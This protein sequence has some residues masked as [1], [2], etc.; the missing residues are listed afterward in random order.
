VTGR[1][2]LVVALAVASALSVFLVY[3]AFAGQSRPFVTVAQLQANA[4]GSS[5]RSIEL[6]GKVT[7]HGALDGGA[8]SMTLRDMKTAQTVD[9]RY[10]GSVPDAFRR[11]REV[12]VKG[13]MQGGVFVAEPDSLVT[14]CP[15][16]YT[17]KNDGR[18]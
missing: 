5:D 8:L 15:S 10:R 3:N 17:G 2:R 14:R 9:V 12:I 1:P 13:R 6:V 11:G 16:K 7:R 4:A 18:V